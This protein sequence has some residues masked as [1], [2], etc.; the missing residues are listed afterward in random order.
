SSPVCTPATPGGPWDRR[1]IPAKSVVS[2]RW[3]R[4]SPSWPRTRRAGWHPEGE[5]RRTPYGAKPFRRFMTDLVTFAE[6]PP[7]H[8]PTL[9]VALEGW[10]DAGGAA[11]GA[12][13]AI[14]SSHSSEAIATFDSDELLDHRARRPT[15]ILS[16]GVMTD[17]VWPTIEMR[18][19]TDGHG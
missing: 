17:L 14:L 19:L 16:E 15:M 18:A 9:L 7:L 3:W 6:H 4:P 13:R 12:A 8:E 5:R 2:G 1:P 11:Q 10:I